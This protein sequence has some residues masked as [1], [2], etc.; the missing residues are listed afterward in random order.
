MIRTRMIW[1]LAMVLV[2]FSCKGK[3]EQNQQAEVVAAG[4]T[5]SEEQMIYIQTLTSL[6]CEIYTRITEVLLK[7]PDAQK[8]SVIRRLRTKRIELLGGVTTVFPDSMAMARFR[9]ELDRIHNSEDFCPALKSMQKDS[10]GAAASSKE[11]NINED[12]RKLAVLNCRILAADTDLKNRA[13]NKR[14]SEALK[15]LRAEKRMLMSALVAAYGPEI[16]ND[17]SFRASVNA[18]QDSDCNYSERVSVNR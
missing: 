14:A 13:G 2:L 1:V 6:D 15:K 18:V 17:K 8:D 7:S 9:D 12:A 11:L 3:K 16:L 5:L 10:L 4:E